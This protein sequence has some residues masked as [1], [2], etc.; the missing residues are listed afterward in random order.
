MCSYTNSINNNNKSN[1]NNYFAGTLE[2]GR[3]IILFRR[4]GATVADKFDEYM[5]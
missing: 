2:K 5:Q 4:E 3:Q 1:N